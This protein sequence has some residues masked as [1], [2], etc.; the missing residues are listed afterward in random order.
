MEILLSLYAT[1]TIAWTGINRILLPV[2]IVFAVVSILSRRK[3][4]GGCLLYF[5]Y[6]AFALLLIL[7]SDIVLHPLAFLPSKSARVNHVA[8]ALAVFPRLVA[9]ISTVATAVILLF[10][11]EWQWVERLRLALWITAII[12]TISVIVDATYFPTSTKP[13]V[14][15]L[16]GLFVWLIYF[17]VSERVERVFRTGE[18]GK[19]H[20][21]TD[22]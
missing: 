10:R 17:Y 7:V 18:W 13:N 12:S 21:T 14:A 1:T 16:V 22:S 2:S 4:I 6:W 8:L 15:R 5:F 3:P 20:N 9:M 11:R 19:A